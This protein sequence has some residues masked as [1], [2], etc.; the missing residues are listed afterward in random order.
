[1]KKYHILAVDDEPANLYLLEEVLGDYFV[2]TV[3]SA[4]DMFNFLQKSIPDLIIL[5]IMI[6]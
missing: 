5:D 3:K 4:H 1:V 6:L 2:D